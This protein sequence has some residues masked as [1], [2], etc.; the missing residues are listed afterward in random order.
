MPLLPSLGALNRSSPKPLPRPQGPEPTSY[1]RVLPS[2]FAFRHLALAIADNLARASGLSVL[3]GL[4]LPNAEGFAMPLTA[5]CA[6]FEKPRIGLPD[7]SA[8]N[9]F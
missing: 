7:K 2:A 6:G 9:S 3:R 4:E 1:K 5:G 8:F